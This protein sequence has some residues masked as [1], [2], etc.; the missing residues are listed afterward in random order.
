M[1]LFPA[2]PDLSLQI[3]PPASTTTTTPPPSWRKQ[4]QDHGNM[5]LGFWRRALASSSSSSSSSSMSKELLHGA[6]FDLSL[7]NP[8]PTDPPHNNNNNSS[9]NLLLHPPH[10]HHHHLHF[11]HHHPQPLLQDGVLM[12][13]IRGIPLYKHHLHNTSSSCTSSPLPLLPHYHHHHHQQHQQQQQQQQQQQLCDHSSSTNNFAPFVA[14]QGLLSRARYLSKFPTKRSVRA[15]RMR[16]TSTLH[17]RFVHAVELL[18]GHER[19]TPKSVLELM[20]VKDLTLAHVKSHLQM[21]RTV[22][23]TDKPVSPGQSDGFENGSTGEISDDNL[24]DIHSTQ[25][26]ES[27]T[28]HGKLGNQHGSNYGGL[29]SNSS[30]RGGWS[31]GLPSESTTGSL[32]NFKEKQPKSF[33]ISDMNSSC[34]SE[35]SSPSKPNLEFTLGRPN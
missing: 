8:S 14:S 13:P 23:N 11:L 10:H 19:A 12:R 3:S 24:G 18:G 30:S 15:P 31:N 9:S 34:L 28:Q 27:S 32:H 7:A 29:W 21:Y 1:E 20:D 22:K 5:E 33:E 35:T 16:W 6:S 2:Q 25:R 4:Q 26:S 17:A